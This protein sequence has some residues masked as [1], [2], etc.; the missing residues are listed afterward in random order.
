MATILVSSSLEGRE[1]CSEP[2]RDSSCR[3]E[4]RR[5]KDLADVARADQG[6]GVL[7]QPYLLVRLLVEVGRRDEH[8]ELAEAQAG[9][10]PAH[11][12]DT[13]GVPERVALRLERELDGKA[14]TGG[15]KEVRP[16]RVTT[17]VT[18]RA[19]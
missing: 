10:K 9:D 11:L 18:V 3:G 6:H 7:V 8:T 14:I 16:D 1:L 15:T 17:A 12:P 19:G 4:A 5:R 2:V 13:K